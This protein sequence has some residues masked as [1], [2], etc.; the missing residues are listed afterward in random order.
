MSSG[1]AISFTQVSW[2]VSHSAVLRRSSTWRP[3][4]LISNSVFLPVKI[5]ALR[6]WDSRD[7]PDLDSE[8]KKGIWAYF[9]GTTW[10]PGGPFKSY[11]VIAS[12]EGK[13]LFTIEGFEIARAPDAEP[14][15][16][17]DNSREERLTTIWQPKAFPSS[18]KS[19][20]SHAMP[21]LQAT[22]D[23]AVDLDVALEALVGEHFCVAGTPS[24]A[25]AKT[26]ILR[27]PHAR[28]LVDESW[29][30]DKD[31]TNTPLASFDAVVHRVDLA[32]VQVDVSFITNI[33]GSDGVVL[34]S[35]T[36]SGV[37]V[38]DT[39]VE[40][41][42]LIMKPTL[43]IPCGPFKTVIVQPFEHSQEGDLIEIA[44]NI[45][46]EAEL[47][48]IGND[49]AA[50]IGALG[51][52]SCIIAESPEYQ[53]F[54]VLFEDHS[55][56]EAAREKIAHDLRKNSLLLLEQH[57]GI[58]KNGDVFVRR[59]VHGGEDVKSA[60]ISAAGLTGASGALAAYFPP[61]LKSSD[62]EIE[63]KALGIEPSASFKS[64]LTFI[65]RV[66]S[67][68]VSVGC[69]ETGA[70]AV[71]T[72]CQAP[73]DVIIVPQD[74]VVVLPGGISATDAAAL[75]VT[76]LA[77][78]IGLVS[79]APISAASTVL[80]RDATSAAVQVAKRFNAKVFAIVGR[81]HE[82]D[83]LSSDLGIMISNIVLIDDLFLI[84]AEWIRSGAMPQFDVI[85]NGSRKKVFTRGLEYPSP[86]GSYVHIQ[87][88]EAADIP[89]G[90]ASSY[91]LDD[92]RLV[93]AS[94]TLL[95][96]SSSL[97]AVS[98]YKGS[99]S[100]DIDSLVIIPGTSRSV[101]IDPAGQLFDPRKSYILVGRCSELG[102]R[103]NEWMVPASYQATPFATRRPAETH[104]TGDRA[105]SLRRTTPP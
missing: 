36:D 12:S 46:S 5:D 81:R 39:S 42:T 58:S 23:I 31:A 35:V 7:A 83:E 96:P 65:G 67:R 43:T 8:I 26:G 100:E 27:Y 2:V 54:S 79:R 44:K 68:G 89:S 93:A 53:V 41:L 101:R 18:L 71:G 73:A 59:L 28:S 22:S 56:D 87:S 63:V 40:P 15:P 75:P 34:L 92:N 21:P 60:C 62:V 1:K 80:V 57:M 82:V 103:I 49:D 4:N 55:L 51:V 70:E 11:F 69:V 66:K 17:T 48:I 25:D 78:W 102:V 30:I 61:S 19:T 37:E 76:F 74:M 104:A 72:T 10:A 33:V 95:N 3:S 9:T 32:A 50:G 97:R 84:P 38:E 88:N 91:L 45:S 90:A 20:P 105:W 98:S 86:F 85:F 94:P 13:V 6:H 52:A 29:N 64:A 14:I 16:I 77:A 24:E 47:W 99:A